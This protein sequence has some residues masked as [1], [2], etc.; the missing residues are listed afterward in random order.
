MKVPKKDAFSISIKSFVLFSILVF[1]LLSVRA[2]AV[3][4]PGDYISFWKFE[5]GAGTTIF[6]DEAG[7]N[8][9][10]SSG[11]LCPTFIDA[12]GPDGSG[13]Y[14]FDDNDD[15][16][17][18]GSDSSLDDLGPLTVSTW[19]YY[20][21]TEDGYGTDGRIVAKKTDNNTG[22]WGFTINDLGANENTLAFWSAHDSGIMRRSNDNAF[23]G[24][25]WHNVTIT[26]DANYVEESVKFYVDAVEVT[27]YKDF[28][29]WSDN[30]GSDSTQNLYIGSDGTGNH[31]FDGIIDNV[32]IYNRQLSPAEIASVYNSETPE[33]AT[34]LMLLFG[35]C[36]FAAARRRIIER[37]QRIRTITPG[38][39]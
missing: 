20:Y 32:M 15:Y 27:G 35:S 39:T 34:G 23:S 8:P 19:I 10:S 38:A 21:D 2:A 26:W 22:S 9:G 24:N 28:S 37:P 17:D 4:L 29:I 16:I 14:E 11:D 33:P 31:T 36:I 30:K 6:A 5:D 13:A 7:I 12:G 25:T 3:D 1:A 18:L